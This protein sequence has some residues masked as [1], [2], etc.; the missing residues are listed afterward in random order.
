MKAIKKIYYVLLTLL[1]FIINTNYIDAS[2]TIKNGTYT[3]KS[4]KDNN[5]VIDVYK[6]SANNGTNVQ[7]Y[8]S[9]NNKNQ[10][11]IITY[12]NGYYKI[13]SN[14]DSTKV[15]DISYAKF[16][17][18][19]NVTLYTDH[20]E[21]N[22][23]WSIKHTGNGYFKIVSTNDNYCLDMYGGNTTNGTNIQIYK[24]NNSNAQKFKLTEVISGTKTIDDD[25]YIITTALNN[26]KAIDINHGNVANKTNVEIYD[27]KES[28]NQ[29]WK[30]K[31]LNNGYYQITSR[32]SNKVCLDVHGGNFIPN[33]NIEIYSCNSSIA[34]KFIIKETEEKDGYYYIIT[35]NDHMYL[36]IYNGIT[37]NGNNLQINYGDGTS[38]QKFKFIKNE[39]KTLPDGIYNIKTTLNKQKSLDI[40]GGNVENDKPVKLYTSTNN[41]NQKWYIKKDTDGYYTIKSLS[42]SNLYLTT[43]TTS[44]VSTIKTKWEIIYASEDNYY[45]KETNSQKYLSIQNNKTDNG[46][47]LELTTN[48]NE[49]AQI[50][51]LEET[52]INNNDRTIPDGYYTINSSLD[53]SKVIDINHAYKANGTN[54]EIYQ[55]NNGNNQIWNIKY[56]KEGYY[57]I[58]SSMNPNLSLDLTGGNTVN[59]TNIELYRYNG[60]NAQLWKI[61]D[62]KNGNISISP[63]TSTTICLTIKNS[64]TENG[65]NIQAETCNNSN[66]QKFKLNRYS[67]QKIYKGV[68]I[69]QYQKNIN[70]ENFSKNVD[71]VILRAG[72]GDNYTSQ[73][74]K[75]FI[76][77]VNNCNKYNIPYGVYLYSYAKRVQKDS[78][79]ANLNYNAESAIS[80]AAHVKRLLNSVSYKPNLKTS[81]YLDIE[82]E[83]LGYLGKTLQTN[84]ANKFCSIIESNGYGCSVYANLNWLKNHIDTNNLTT[85]NRLWLAY[86]FDPAHKNYKK[87]ISTKPSYNLS[88]YKLWQFSDKGSISGYNTVID[89]DIGYDIFD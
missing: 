25:N 48:S 14:L 57:T 19:S 81:V 1:T 50:F 7:L 28:I 16:A 17:N 88:N 55:S 60:S 74:D 26:N 59:G 54:I 2:Q 52:E 80:E 85:K 66:N 84:I 79:D 70:W 56:L 9:N 31:Y 38:K 49:S 10:Q 41:N 32:L 44:K 45:L 20:N 3:I 40:Y 82:E 58:T 24:C 42:N 30:V 4:Y 63:K 11:W 65:T 87:A 35:P 68:D 34:Q 69:S 39:D 46:T 29:Q 27:T 5:Q 77:N 36:D 53:I 6:G 86:W 51:Y 21:D 78:K 71:F 23:K 18:K 72:Y 61:I 64:S 33:N 8:S 76:E 37:T 22:Q 89:L 15:L 73:D 83:K 13:A 75:L 43:N 12:Q 62:D 47:E 67:N